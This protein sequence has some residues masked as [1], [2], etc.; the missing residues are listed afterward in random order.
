MVT[1]QTILPLI[2]ARLSPIERTLNID[3]VNAASR[4]C[5]P[6]LIDHVN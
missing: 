5:A 4:P 1:F 2:K 3:R 6:T